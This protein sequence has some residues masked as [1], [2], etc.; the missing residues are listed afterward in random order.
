MS[1]KVVIDTF[2]IFFQHILAYGRKTVAYRGVRTVHYKLILKAGRVQFLIKKGGREGQEKELFRTFN[3]RAV[4]HLAR[5]CETDWEWLALAQHH[6]LPTRL[7]DWS[8]NPL[9]AAYFAIEKEHRGDSI[10][11]ALPIGESLDLEKNPDPFEV[12]H[13]CRVYPPHVTPRIAAQTGIFTY[14][15]NPTIPFQSPDLDIYVIPRGFRRSLKFILYR[16]GVTQAALFPG[17]DGLAEHIKWL[18]V[19]QY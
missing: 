5:K 1:K 14:H 19:K 18:R 8:L 2:E 9:V 7:L 15:P 4:P 13:F 17:L 6:G 11:Y 16:F 3:K 10:I 12:D